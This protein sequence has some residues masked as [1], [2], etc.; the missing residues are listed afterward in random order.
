MIEALLA[1]QKKKQMAPVAISDDLAR[2]IMG[3]L[4]D[5]NPATILPA[6]IK[7]IQR[8]SKETGMTLDNGLDD[9]LEAIRNAIIGYNFVERFNA[10]WEQYG[11]AVQEALG[12]LGDVLMMNPPTGEQMDCRDEDG[13]AG[14]AGGTDDTE[15]CCDEDCCCCFE[16]CCC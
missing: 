2:Y 6:M 11:D 4:G 7:V 16:V 1:V 12:S 14:E 3:V 5:V 9:V 15:D 13:G 10:V 8:A